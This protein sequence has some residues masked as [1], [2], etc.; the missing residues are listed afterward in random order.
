MRFTWSETKRKSNIEKHGFDLA[1]AP[2]VFAGPTFTYEDDRLDYSEQRFVTLGLL[3]GV[4][5]LSST[6]KVHV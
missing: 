6:P 2:Q 4:W 3:F 5:L 1:D